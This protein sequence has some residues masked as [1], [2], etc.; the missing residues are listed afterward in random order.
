MKVPRTVPLWIFLFSGICFAVS[1]FFYVEFTFA[2]FQ[3][4]DYSQLITWYNWKQGLLP[5]SVYYFELA[6]VL[7]AFGAGSWLIQK[8]PKRINPPDLKMASFSP[9]IS[10]LRGLAALGVVLYH[11]IF[12]TAILGLPL[13][14]GGWEGVGLFLMLSMFLLLSS[15]DKNS[16]LKHYFWRR[17]KR[18]WP[19]YYGTVTAGFLLYHFA[20]G[21]LIQ[22][23][24]FTQYYFNPAGIGPLGVF[25][26]L[27]LEE[28]MYLIIPLIHKSN[29]KQLIAYA[30]IG[31]NLCASILISLVDLFGAQLIPELTSLGNFILESK[32]L[33]LYW[34]PVW[35]ASYGFGILVYLNPK[36]IPKFYR[37]TV[38]P[39]F[40]FIAAGEGLM[41]DAV[42]NSVRIGI[43]FR[44][45]AYFLM[46]P[47]FASLVANP[48]G[49]LRY[50]AVLGEGSYGIY[51][52]Q[53]FFLMPFGMIGI[54][55]SV[56]A[57]VTVELAM[58]PLNFLSR[59]RIAYERPRKELE[60]TANILVPENIN[61]TSE[62]VEQ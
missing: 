42:A 31:I 43:P 22:Y 18:I 2:G 5:S 23:F 60:Q 17:I 30:L 61:S 58:R 41:G 21:D 29:H 57:G 59:L 34:F 26:T 45:L 7:A 12:L 3:G 10:G 24:T 33:Q 53:Y 51:A 44:Q 54:L 39:I 14:V 55:Y 47:G 16:N 37:L 48:P 46:L 1:L 4:A 49:F 25:W 36:S 28:A 62:D 6:L 38:L 19:I 32:S 56:I 11:G 50:F 8:S 52:V 9:E 13:F 27:Q 35:L 20:I 15:L 40:L